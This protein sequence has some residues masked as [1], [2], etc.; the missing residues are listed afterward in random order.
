MINKCLIGKHMVGDR[1]GLLQSTIP[2][3][4][5]RDWRKQKQELEFDISRIQSRSP[6]QLAFDY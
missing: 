3:I 1:R 5:L 2:D 4:V 6:E